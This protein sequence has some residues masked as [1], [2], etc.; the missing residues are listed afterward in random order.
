MEKRR[1]RV[2]HA[3]LLLSSFKGIPVFQCIS[4]YLY[5]A[6]KDILCVIE[7]WDKDSNVGEAY[8]GDASID[9][10][11]LLEMVD[12]F[13]ELLEEGRMQRD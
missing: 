10:D 11:P 2:F 4:K 9:R 8:K 5:S 3:L 7:G 1:V 12:I 13:I 6:F